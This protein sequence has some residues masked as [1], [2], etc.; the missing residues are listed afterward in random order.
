[1]TDDFDEAEGLEQLTPGEYPLVFWVE[2]TPI[3]LNTHVATSVKPKL[4]LWQNRYVVP[5]IEMRAFEKQAEKIIRLNKAI[6]R[7][8]SEIRVN[9]DKAFYE[10]CHGKVIRIIETGK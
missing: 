7:L 6:E 10:H 4:S 5:M 2:R 8:F 3:A 9:T 1:M